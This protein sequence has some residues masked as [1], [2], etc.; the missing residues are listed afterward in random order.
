LPAALV[1]D[2]HHIKNGY[3]GEQEPAW[4]ILPA[5]IFTVFS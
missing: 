1:D 2:A 5:S 4:Q 3:Q